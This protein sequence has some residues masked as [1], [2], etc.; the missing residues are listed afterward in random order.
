MENFIV[1]SGCVIGTIADLRL[2][3]SV[4]NLEYIC[5]VEVDQ[6]WEEGGGDFFFRQ[7]SLN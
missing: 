7:I 5:V 4:I 6:I 1:R 3:C 2:L